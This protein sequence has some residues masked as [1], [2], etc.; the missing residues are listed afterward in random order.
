MK[1]LIHKPILLEAPEFICYFI[2]SI[3]RST[4]PARIETLVFWRESQNETS[5]S[6]LLLLGHLKNA[7]I[8]GGKVLFC[9][10]RS[11]KLLPKNIAYYSSR[12]LHIIIIY[13]NM[14]YCLDM[15][16]IVALA[17]GIHTFFL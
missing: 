14:K 5:G 12:Y 16:Q 11:P 8:A 10:H 6:V 13:Q 1:I 9:F 4:R 7:N 2:V 17:A 15:I 3:P